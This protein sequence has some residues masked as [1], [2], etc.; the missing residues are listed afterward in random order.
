M[1]GPV[2]FSEIK[3][4]HEELKKILNHLQGSAAQGPS[5]AS[6]EQRRVALREEVVRL[7]ASLVEHF[8]M[9]EEGG[10]LEAATEAGQGYSV[11]RLQRQHTEILDALGQV[12]EACRSG[13][14][15]DRAAA[16][17]R[18]VIGQLRE[19]EAEECRLMQDAVIDDIGTG[20]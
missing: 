19:H 6:A 4:Q 10:Y 1:E 17:V 12:A 20:D 15:L 5:T 14:A 11:A 13:G 3:R 2:D 16:R 18:E 7:R 8:R 9:E